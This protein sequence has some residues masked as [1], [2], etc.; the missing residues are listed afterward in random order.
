MWIW[1]VNIVST[2]I[3]IDNDGVKIDQG[4]GLRY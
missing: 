3:E 4:L 2:I 1:A